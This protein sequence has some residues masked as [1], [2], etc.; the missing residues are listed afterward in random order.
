MTGIG[1]VW[2]SE[3]IIRSDET[4]GASIRQV[5][6]FPAIHHHPFFFIPSYDTAMT[7]LIFVSHRTGRPEI[8]AED[9]QSG[10]LIQ[11]TDGEGLDEW[12]VYPSRNGKWVLFTRA[13]GAWRLHLDDLRTEQLYRFPAGSGKEAGMVGAAMG[14]TA[15]SWDDRW[16]AVPVK[17]GSGFRLVVIDLETGVCE[18]VLEREKIGH[19]QFCPD[20][21][22][23]I[24]YI[25]DMT[26]RTWVVGRDG[27]DNR[28]IYTRN[29]E[30]NE[31]ITHESWIPGTREVAIVDWPKGIRAIHVDSG[32][33]R[34][35]CTFN[36]WHAICNRSGNLMV[37]D[38]NFPDNGVQI[39]DPLDGAGHPRHLCSPEAS[40]AGDH[41]GGPFPYANGPINVYAP[42]HTHVHPSF[43]P[44]DSRIVYTSDVT[45]HAQVYECLLDPSVD[46]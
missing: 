10:D 26:D 44:D 29:V 35:V 22:N 34:Q 37:A 25:A 18:E 28:L 30:R 46:G 1:R 7:R 24:L 6:N 36:A 39:L 11:L 14:T 32:A 43:S 41:W 27:A 33:D 20:D 42:Q 45:G 13:A 5:T 9:R 21:P 17:V 40:Q 2:P 8:F 4:T 3:A 38:T 23:L 12:S 31:W 16:W 15:L 19:P